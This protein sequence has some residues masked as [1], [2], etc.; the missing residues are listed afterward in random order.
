ML[1]YFVDPWNKCVKT[2]WP[3]L[4]IFNSLY[5]PGFGPW[6]TSALAIKWPFAKLF[7]FRSVS[8]N[9]LTTGY[10]VWLELNYR[11]FT[12]ICL[13]C[14]GYDKAKFIS[15]LIF[16]DRILSATNIPSF[17]SPSL[18]EQQTS[19]SALLLDSDLLSRKD[20]ITDYSRISVCFSQRRFGVLFEWSA[21]LLPIKAFQW[22]LVY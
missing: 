21:E 3:K 14:S 7:P 17:L 15:S 18:F 22:N 2:L 6:L 16:P 9:L 1:P 13:C 4:K 5:M 10:T 11:D 20:V 8:S 19:Y 12:E